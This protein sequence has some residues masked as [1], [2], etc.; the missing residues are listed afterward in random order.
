MIKSWVVPLALAS[1]LGLVGTAHAQDPARPWA[2]M[3]I[4]TGMQLGV[5]LPQGSYDL[6]NPLITRLG[7]APMALLEI[8]YR[9][10]DHYSFGAL[11]GGGLGTST[12]CDSEGERSGCQPPVFGV[13]SL[14]FRQHLVP[15]GSAEPWMGAGLGGSLLRVPESGRPP[16][17]YAT[18]DARGIL[19]GKS[20]THLGP[21]LLLGAGVSWRAKPTMT[22]GFAAQVFAGPYLYNRGTY[23]YSQGA[24]E[25]RTLPFPGLHAFFLLSAHVL[26]HTRQ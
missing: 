1:G 8:S 15:I 4:S 20:S 26:F 25:S 3:P 2:E 16:G 24:E 17:D 6:A 19:D 7:I 5:A 11:A 18:G 23:H 14:F 9:A 13:A 22:I 21:E 10:T 12:A